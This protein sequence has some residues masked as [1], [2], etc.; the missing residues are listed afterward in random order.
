MEIGR[1]WDLRKVVAA[2]YVGLLCM[3]LLLGLTPAQATEYEAATS[4]EIPSI[5]L[6]ADVELMKMKNGKLATPDDAVGGYSGAANKTFLVGHVS[7]VFRD[8]QDVR[9]GDEIVYDLVRYNV[10]KVEVLKKSDINMDLLL[11]P[12][13]KD[14]IVVMTCAG[15]RIS[16]GDATHRLIITASVE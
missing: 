9:V 14:T 15:E 16:A 13:E 11:L 12:E 5:G 3:Y 10:S 7:N 6:V 2:V 8:L 4:I 1:S